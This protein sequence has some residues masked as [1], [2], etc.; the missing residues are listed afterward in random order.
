MV[1]HT[2][3]DMEVRAVGRS[4]TVNSDICGRRTGNGSVIVDRLGK[5]TN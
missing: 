5:I 1:S 2:L 4:M 3:R